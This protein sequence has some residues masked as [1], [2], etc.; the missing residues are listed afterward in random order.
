MSALFRQS[1]DSPR[2]LLPCEDTAES[3]RPR[4]ELSRAFAASLISDFQ[5]VRSEDL[6]FLSR[7]TYGILISKPGWTRA[8]TG[9]RSGVLLSLHPN[10]GKRSRQR[11]GEWG[12]GRKEPTLTRVDP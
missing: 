3:L 11:L 7:P 2:P 4:R 9:A 5:T 10:L 1:P 6:L 8:E 12:A